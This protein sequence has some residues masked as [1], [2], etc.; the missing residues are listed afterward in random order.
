MTAYPDY[1]HEDPSLPGKAASYWLASGSYQPRPALDGDISVE[2]AVI[3]AGLVGA[4]T[5]YELATAGHEVL[6][7]ERDTV[8]SDVTGHTTAKVTAVHGSVLSEALTKLGER[9]VGRHVAANHLAVNRIG[10]LAQHL[11]IACD[12]AHV[13]TIAYVEDQQQLSA[14]QQAKNALLAGALE[15]VDL[16]LENL[17]VR[18]HGAFRIGKELRFHPV[19]FGAGILKAAE[20]AGARICEHTRVTK[21]DDH[22]GEVRLTTNAGTVTAQ[23]A[24]VA[25]HYPFHDH[26]TL[27]SRLFPYRS[28]VLGAYIAQELP[29]RF[30]IALDEAL[31]LR[32]HPAEK[33]DLVIASA[34]HHKAGEGGDE[35]ERYQELERMLRERYDVLDIPWHWSTQDNHTPDGLPFIGRSPGAERTWVVSGFAAWGMSQS[36]VAAEMIADFLAGESHPLADL[37]D[38]GRFEAGKPG[39]TFVKENV[40]VAKELATG[41]FSEGS[42]DDIKP[43]EG[44]RIRKGLHRVAAYR[45]FD[46][47]LHEV[48]AACTHVGCGIEFNDAEKT[49][50]CPCHGSR[51]DIDGRVIHGPAVRDLEPR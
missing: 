19:K 5:A 49:W 38:P 4:L 18:A 12:L 11:E 42:V 26:G 51:F 36:L 7:L 24:V 3:G 34:V 17:G 50:D 32:L 31:T 22:G 30:Y 23:Y 25:T 48:S 15:P 45:D 20:Q 40:D 8:L 2:V 28:Y 27:F 37:Y 35:R 16:E 47:A 43:G 13:D 1:L 9:A 33:G 44:R 39:A 41:F 10:E 14:L 21:L 46:G 29:D 6:L